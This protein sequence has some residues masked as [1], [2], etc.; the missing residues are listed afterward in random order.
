M[1]ESTESSTAQFRS[2]SLVSSGELYGR[3]INISKLINKSLNDLIQN[4]KIHKTTL[5]TSVVLQKQNEKSKRLITLY[6]LEKMI[7]GYLEVLIGSSSLVSSV[8]SIFFT[9]FEC[10]FRVTQSLIPDF[11]YLNGMFN[12]IKKFIGDQSS[13]LETSVKQ[14]KREFNDEIEMAR[15]QV[16]LTVVFNLRNHKETYSRI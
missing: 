4:I 5:K 16:K 15:S 9:R 7:N 1:E 11:E 2:S 3:L 12:N 8:V 13:S 6:S 14:F 10:S